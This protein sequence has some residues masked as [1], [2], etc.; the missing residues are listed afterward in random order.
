[1]RPFYYSKST[2]NRYRQY[3]PFSL[4]GIDCKVLA[5]LRKS[6]PLPTPLATL[7]HILPT[8]PQIIDVHSPSHTGKTHLLYH[9]IV[10]TILPD[11]FPRQPTRITSSPARAVFFID[12]DAR[13]DVLRLR[14]LLRTFVR[15]KLEGLQGGFVHQQPVQGPSEEEIV[16]CV[17]SALGNLYLFQ[18]MS[19]IGL[20]ATVKSLPSF[21][22]RVENRNITLGL[23]CI[24]SL[25]AF[26]HVLRSMDKLAEYYA[27]LCSSLRSLS[28]LLGIPV[29]T[30]S[31]ALFAQTY[32]SQ[33]QGKG[34]LG[35]GPSHPQSVSARR[36]VWKQYFPV[37][38][39]RGVDCRIIL[40]KRE[41]RGFM[42][43]I[44]LADAEKDKDKRMEVVK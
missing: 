19:G 12:C 15:G 36:P 35:T 1:M 23:I 5:S 18:P 11:F 2:R 10:Q 26:H 25:T 13:F 33:V 41:V 30:T 31:W 9:L 3:F 32:T 22:S 7:F 39:L 24:D 28:S 16:E 20:L 44:P 38:W 14:H 40:Q 17:D 27:T 34:N 4:H 21:L 8:P 6:A 42:A 29:I 37:E 43:D